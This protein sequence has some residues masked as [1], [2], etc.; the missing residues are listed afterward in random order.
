WSSPAGGPLVDAYLVG[1][2]SWYQQISGVDARMPGKQVVRDLDVP[3]ISVYSGSQ[4]VVDHLVGV[5]TS[6]LRDDFDA[7]RAGDRTYEL[8]GSAHSARPGCGLPA[9]DLRLGNL[10]HLA[11]D[12]LVRWSDGELV[13]PHAQRVVLDVPAE[14]GRPRPRLDV[15]GNAVGGVRSVQLD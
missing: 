14:D 1:E 5:G 12:Y 8:A 10:F 2:P 3:V 13:P 6:R 9:S 7:P 4:H 11:F 15:H